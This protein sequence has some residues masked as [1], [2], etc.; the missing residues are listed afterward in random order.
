M[1]GGIVS[2]VDGAKFPCDPAFG[3]EDL[4]PRTNAK[5]AARFAASSTRLLSTSIFNP[6]ANFVPGS[7]AIM[8][9]SYSSTLSDS[10]ARIS[11]NSL[12]WSK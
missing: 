4:V 6:S 12:A 9:R 10:K 8:S 5:G 11:E 1:K 2:I 7:N 3:S